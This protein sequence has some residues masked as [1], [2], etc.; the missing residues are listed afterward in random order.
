[1][2]SIFNCAS[3]ARTLEFIGRSALPVLRVGSLDGHKVHELER[4]YITTREVA[5]RL[6][7]SRRTVREKIRTG[8][9]RRGV[10]FFEPAHTRRFWRWSSVVAWVESEGTGALIINERLR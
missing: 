8:V 2:A 4:E 5:A 1:M 9:F 7:W 6:R 10:H 3:A